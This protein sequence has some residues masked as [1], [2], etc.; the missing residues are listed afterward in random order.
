MTPAGTSNGLDVQ[1]EWE[2]KTH[3]HT[4]RERE[5][6]LMCSPSYKV[7]KSHT[8]SCLAIVIG[9]LH[10]DK[11]WDTLQAMVPTNVKTAHQTS[12]PHIE[13][14]L[15]PLGLLS[16]THGQRSQQQI[17]QITLQPVL[18]NKPNFLKAARHAE[19]KNFS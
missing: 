17:G 14:N 15:D 13:S 2:E 10:E 11:L 8:K 7:I 4:E 1:N 18:I 3:T 5:E 16:P 12:L 19:I 9:G 6:C